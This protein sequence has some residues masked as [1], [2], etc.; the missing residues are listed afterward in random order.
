M[1][2]GNFIINFNQINFELKLYFKDIIRLW[3]AFQALDCQQIP[4]GNYKH[5]FAY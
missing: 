4:K 5:N 1:L 2:C 3:F